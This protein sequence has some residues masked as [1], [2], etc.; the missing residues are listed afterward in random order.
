MFLI[1]DNFMVIFTVNTNSPLNNFNILKK[2][3][4]MFETC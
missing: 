1:P 3:R 4:R 2:K